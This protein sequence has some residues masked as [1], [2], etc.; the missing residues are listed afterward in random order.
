MA[1]EVWI[2]KGH[3]TD[4]EAYRNDLSALDK[5][6]I[7]DVEWQFSDGPAGQRGGSS[8]YLD[9]E[10]GLIEHSGYVMHW[11]EDNAA[12]PFMDAETID[13]LTAEQ[14]GQDRESYSDSQDRDSYTTTPTAAEHLVCGNIPEAYGYRVD[15]KTAFCLLAS[16]ALQQRA[17]DVAIGEGGYSWALWDPSD[18]A[19]G[20]LL[21]GDNPATLR[22]AFAEEFPDLVPE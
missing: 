11:Q 8:D 5:V 10:Q 3:V 18:D 6:K 22:K 1:K 2:V 7:G 13:R 17:D 9:L 12:W 19:N 15:G 14:T 21:T 16:P 4:V 20:F